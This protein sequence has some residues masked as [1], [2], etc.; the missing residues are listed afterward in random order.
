MHGT[1]AVNLD[2]HA[3]VIALIRQ[4][5][6]RIEGVGISW[7]DSRTT[8]AIRAY[9]AH[10]MDWLMKL[11]LKRSDA[12]RRVARVLSN[13]GFVFGQRRGE[14]HQTVAAWRDRLRR[15]DAKGFGASVY[16]DLRSDSLEF[17][18][19]DQEAIRQN[20]LMRLKHLVRAAGVNPSD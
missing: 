13:A 10:T 12:S 9:S 19:S 6:S 2:S 4:P 14:P 15:F 11:G 18:S 1:R 20:F 3:Q 5:N 8:Q 16:E 17:G 7:R